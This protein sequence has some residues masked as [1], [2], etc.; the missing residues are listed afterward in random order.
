VTIEICVVEV[1]VDALV[2]SKEVEE[3]EV[4]TSSWVRL[5]EVPKEDGDDEDDEVPVLSTEISDDD[6]R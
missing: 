3:D 4:V 5:G 1:D 6:C 2:K